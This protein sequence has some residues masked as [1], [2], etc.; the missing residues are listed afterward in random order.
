[1]S[2]GVNGLSHR[3]ERFCR[4]YVEWGCAAVAARSARYAPRWSANHGYRLLKQPRIRGRI[5]EIQAEIAR[6]ACRHGDVLLGKLEM[7][8]RRALQDR[9]FYAAARAVDLQAKLAVQF[10]RAGNGAAAGQISGPGLAVQPL[11]IPQKFAEM[12]SFDEQ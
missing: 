8:Y 6:D 2:R 3:Q 5:A 4:A 1:M 7:V 10:A 12:T 9:S 11:E